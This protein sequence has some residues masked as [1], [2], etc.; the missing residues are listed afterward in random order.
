M[1]KKKNLNE[2]FITDDI[3]N[4]MMIEKAVY[5]NI[6]RVQD[7]KIDEVHRRLMEMIDARSIDD[8]KYFEVAAFRELIKKERLAKAERLAKKQKALSAAGAEPV[9]SAAWQGDGVKHQPANFD[10]M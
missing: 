7:K 2:A 8:C 10:D 9:K 3:K 1:A 4:D 6:D 5:N